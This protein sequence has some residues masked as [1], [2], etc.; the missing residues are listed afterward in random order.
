MTGSLVRP[1]R[2]EGS[3]N[4][5]RTLTSSE[6]V[7]YTASQGMFTE[8]MNENSKWKS[9][10]ERLCKLI[11]ASV[12]M[13]EATGRQGWWVKRVFTSE[14]LVTMIR[15]GDLPRRQLFH[16]PLRQWG[17]LSRGI[18]HVGKDHFLWVGLVSAFLRHR[19]ETRQTLAICPLASCFQKTI[20]SVPYKCLEKC[21]SSPSIS[22]IGSL[23]PA[24]QCWAW[25]KGV[26]IRNT[27]AERFFG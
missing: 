18:F 10:P 19:W 4:G 15:P 21:P 22:K 11:S 8:W 23:M 25:S 6:R 13:A 24:L 9:F 14:L 2:S 20:H 17:H 1:W 16:K 26:G 3:Q 7:G 27:G 12:G 5:Q